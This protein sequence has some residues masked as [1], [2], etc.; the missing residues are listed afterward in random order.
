M[1]LTIGPVAI[2]GRAFLAPMSG[3]TDVGLR[4]L[5]RRFGASLVVSEMVAS[6]ELARG[7]EE[8]RMRAEGEGVSPHVVQLAGCDPYWMAEAARVAQEAGADIIDINMGCPAKKV[9][10]GWAGSALMRDLDHAL[11]LIEAVVGAVRVPVTLKMRL[12]WDDANRNAPELACRAETAG[13]Q[14]VTVHGRT[15]QQF[16]KGSADWAAVAAVRAATSLPLV[17]NGNICDTASAREALRLSGADAVMVG[18]AAVGR[19]WLVGEIARDLAG[20]AAR[21]GC[22]L[23]AEAK[24][25]AAVEHYE[26]LL[27]L[28]GR[29][30]GLRHARKH[31]AAYADHAIELGSARARVERARIVTSET[32][33]QVIAALRAMFADVPLED[34]A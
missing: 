21:S 26:T 2:D 20:D 33:Q 8:A 34:A 28:Y 22:V 15:R 12:G 30:M 27:S 3:V 32:P 11:R 13:V 19:P 16:Y 24:G 6:Q 10:G 1:T 9:T 7:D 31:L 17:V 29:D 23:D 14:L 25:A 4:R 18:R 5:A